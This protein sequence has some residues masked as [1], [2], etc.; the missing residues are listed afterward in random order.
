MYKNLFCILRMQIFL[1]NMG[2]DSCK[3]DFEKGTELCAITY[4]PQGY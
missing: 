4:T 3:T 2:Q 1:E